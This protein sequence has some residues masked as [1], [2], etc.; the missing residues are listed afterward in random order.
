MIPAFVPLTTRLRRRLAA[1]VAVAVTAFLPLAAPTTPLAQAADREAAATGGYWMVASDGGIFSFGGASFY[2]STGNIK[3]NQPIVGIAATPSGKGYWMVATDGG[4]FSFGDAQFFGSTGNVKLNKPIVGMASSP[5]GN[6]Y[7]FVASDGGIFAFGDAAFFGSAGNIKLAKPITAMATTPSGK[8]YWFT[9][10]DGGIFNYGDA[11]FFGAAPSRPAPAG[12]RSVA[13]MVPTP[14]GSGYWQAS[15][16]GELLAFGSA[17]DLGGLSGALAKPIVG[18]TAAPVVAT[19]PSVTIPGPGPGPGPGGGG[20]TDTTGPTTITTTPPYTG[21]MRFSDTALK[22][23]G[24]PGD[25]NKSRINS[26]ATE[27]DCRRGVWDASTGQ[28]RVY[29]YSEKVQAIVEIGDRVYIGGYFADLHQNN[30][31]KTPTMSGLPMEYLAQLDTNGNPVPGSAFNNRV[32][33]NG[34]VRALVGSPDGRRL[35]VGGEFNQVNGQSRPRLVAL[36]PV[37]GEIDPSFNPPTPNAY[38]SSLALNGNTL[39]IGGGFDRLGTDTT[40]PQLA[41]LNATTGEIDGRF[42]PPPR[43][44]GKFV[45]NTG[46]R[47][48]DPDASDPNIPDGPRNCSKP[49]TTDVTGV[50]EALLLSP[51]GRH[52][53]VGGSFLHFGF[54]HTEDPTYKHS[55]LIA[56]DPVTG[57][58]CGRTG[59]SCTWLPEYDDDASR[60]IFGMAPYRGDPKSIGVDAA[61]MIF[62]ASGGAGGRVI[63]W[64]PGGKT[65]YLWRGQMD[66]DAMSVVSTQDRVYVV[67]H[68]D[69]TVP[70]PK[71]P[72]LQ[73][74]DQDPNTPGDQLGVSCPD[75]TASRHLAAFHASGELDSRGRNTR[76]AI[77][78]PDFKAQ[79][80]TSEGPYYVHLGASR[81]YVGGNFTD[82]ANFPTGRS[83]PYQDTLRCKAGP[84]PGFAVYPSLS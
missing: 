25:A 56:V 15:S 40:R 32:S 9:A 28:C 54:S 33:L 2:G 6:G 67:G 37:T 22:S 42:T 35:Y 18:M 64:V 17:A 72:C 49:G 31:P 4:I 16:T 29:P 10:S 41:A 57:T 71:D 39:Y 11:K 63:A 69:H 83:C 44:R 62:T 48:A 50:V 75:G 38:V 79:A 66:G 80:D 23:W 73:L 36:D 24:T 65:T 12:G 3:L 51:D 60:P 78:D 1:A 19:G 34:A 74:R 5:T 43:Y 77:L 7:W 8:G 76:K 81:M 68:F 26:A 84:Q 47:C 59:A 52:L 53:I 46:I 45:G 30:H 82:I 27:A 58:L 20:T 21:P 13:A 61:Q 14:D 70:D 55:G